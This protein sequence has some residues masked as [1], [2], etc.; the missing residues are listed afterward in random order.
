M[1]IHQITF[2]LKI[3]YIKACRLSF[4]RSD[5]YW[6]IRIRWPKLYHFLSCINFVQAH[7]ERGDRCQVKLVVET[8]CHAPTG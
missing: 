4:T 7:T 1:K 5:I 3:Q 8:V 6:K 2:I